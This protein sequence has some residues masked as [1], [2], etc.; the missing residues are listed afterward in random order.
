MAVVPLNPLLPEPPQNDTV[1]SMINRIHSS[2][3][4]G[5]DGADGQRTDDD[6]GDH[7]IRAMG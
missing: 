5:H 7:E 2:A 4:T 1:I 3:T 6:D